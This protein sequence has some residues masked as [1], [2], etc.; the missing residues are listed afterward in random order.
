[1]FPEKQL[2][3]QSQI[4]SNDPGIYYDYGDN[5]LDE[6]EAEFLA[7]VRNQEF[8]AQSK[9]FYGTSDCRLF[10]AGSRFKMDKHYRTD[11]NDEYILTNLTYKG[12]QK[13]L[14]AFL[15]DSKIY[16]PTFECKFEA[17]PFNIEFKPL[18]KT[19]IPKVSGIMSA[20]ILSGPGDEY[21]FVDDH[22]RYKAKLLFDLSDDGSTMPIRLSQFYSGAGYGIHFP[23]HEDTELLWSCVDGN[24]DRPIGLGTVPNPSTATPVTQQNR[25]HNVI[26]T[27]A[28][29]EMVM[30][31]TSGETQISFTTS[32][33]NK[34]SLDDKDDKIEVTTKDKH[35]LTM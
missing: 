23:N 19:P 22:G 28:G 26:R 25:M 24:P 30:D 14:F 8:I 1:M 29:N 7:K 35:K 16:E 11:W 17:I 21:A 2:M 34:I 20:R 18:R 5:F 9:I 31:D 6:K 3:A 33:T 10:R 4:K 12:H 27:A 15:P 32:D 13:S